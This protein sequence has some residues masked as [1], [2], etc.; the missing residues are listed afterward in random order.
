MTTTTP[1]APAEPGPGAPPKRRLVMWTSLGVAALLAALVAVLAT[2][3]TS[4]Q[5]VSG[6]P[7]VGKAAPPVS[8]PDQYGRT[9]TLAA[10]QGR[11]VLVNFAA[12]WCV[13]CQRETPQL[14]SFAARHTGPAAPTIITVAE[15][16]HDLGSL[17][18]F[19]ASRHADW[20]VVDDPGASPQWG[21]GQLP[22]SYVVDPAGTVVALISGGVDADSL[23]RLILSYSS[24]S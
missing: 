7:L 3:N 6:S 2:S 4:G 16:E 11:W 9:V 19:L 13:P 23:D 12:S 15:D 8:G 24:P 22:Q 21:I 5:T 18:R 14:L 10:L 1:A 20:P 17:R